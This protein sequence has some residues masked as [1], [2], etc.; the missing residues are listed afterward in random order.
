MLYHCVKQK[1]KKKKISFSFG[2]YFLLEI[3]PYIIY[4]SFTCENVY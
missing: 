3:A 1:E 4:H 2:K